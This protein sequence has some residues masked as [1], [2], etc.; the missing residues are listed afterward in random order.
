MMEATGTKNAAY[1][2]YPSV[3]IPTFMG[4]SK[5]GTEDEGNGNM[6]KRCLMLS[7]AVLLFRD[8]SLSEDNTKL[9]NLVF[10]EDDT[11]DFTLSSPLEFLD[12][13]K[14]DIGKG[15]YTFP[16]DSHTSFFQVINQPPDSNWIKPEHIPGLI[17][18]MDSKEPCRPVLSIYSSTLPTKLSTTGDEAIFLIQGFRKKRYPP[19]PNSRTY[20]PKER[21][22]IL[23]WWNNWNKQK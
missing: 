12:F 21:K 1:P 17:N 8:I 10:S 22:E 20:S 13:L 5:N 15:V 9:D 3:H 16:N 11:F 4:H 19:E 7:V 2:P 18:L 23:Q 14:K 6:L